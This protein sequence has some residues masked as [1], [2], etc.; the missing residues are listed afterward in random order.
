LCWDI[1]QLFE[2]IK[3]GMKK[4]KELG[5]IPVSMGIDTWAVDF[6]L[7][8]ENDQVIGD[9]VGYRDSR[10][11]MMDQE[12]YKA[13]DEKE[14]Y[15]RT[16]I[17]K[18][19]FN[20]IYQLMAVKKQQPEDLSRAAAMLM[21][22]DYFH[23][24][25]TG[26]KCTEYTNA[27]TTQLL[28]PAAKDW[29]YELI[30]RLGY[31]KQIF[32]KILP[33]GSI[34]GNLTEEIQNEVGFD[35][36]VVL[37]G[38]HDTASAVLAVPSN[39]LSSVYIS[40]GTWS[41]MGIERMEPDCSEKSRELNFT[42]EG[43]YQ[44]RYRYL[45]NIMGL[46]MIQSLKKELHDQ[47]SFAELC[48]LA[49]G[50]SIDSIVNCNDGRFLAP[51]SMKDAIAEVCGESG[52]AIPQSAGDYARVIYRSLACCYRDT[53][54]EIESMTGNTCDAIHVVG[55]GA[56]ADYLNRLIAGMT[57]KAVLAGPTE[58]TAIGNLTAQMLTAG[59]WSSLS[60]AR[61]CI[62]DSFGVKLYQ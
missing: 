5:K 29:D 47:Y 39:D 57:G 33:A 28:N 20:T 1:R 25:L 12:V 18:Q 36:Q 17:Q 2:E 51:A 56:N 14:L 13:I 46:W 41:L 54:K 9:A 49:E 10:T 61:N 44:F 40:S 50:S 59:E 34:L 43:G 48:D 45:K 3:T 35:C 15:A 53:V 27:S 37:P 21:I 62:Y 31:P 8:D 38:T 42:N 19:I 6:V 52:Q 60:E 32:Q 22:P 16:G 26:K 30:D 23:F 58:A 11:E 24:L 7:L 4:C 55:G